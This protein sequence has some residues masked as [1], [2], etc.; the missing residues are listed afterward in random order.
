MLDAL[1]AFNDE[2]VVLLKA[3]QSE[4]AANAGL[5]VTVKYLLDTNILICLMKNRPSGAAESVNAL[6]SAAELCMSF[7]RWPNC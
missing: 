4:Q 7:P 1:T 3:G 6:V 5:Q 2:F